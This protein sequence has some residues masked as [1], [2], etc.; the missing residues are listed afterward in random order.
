MQSD[1]DSTL[2]DQQLQEELYKQNLQSAHREILELQT[3]LQ[4]AIGNVTD[5]S[6]SAKNEVDVDLNH[7]IVLAHIMQLQQDWKVEHESQ[8]QQQQQPQSPDE[9]VLL[10]QARIDELTTALASATN[11]EA[12]TA[13]EVDELRDVVVEKDNTI[14]ELQQQLE[15]AI[16][17][18]SSNH[19]TTS[20]T[21][22]KDIMQDIYSKTCEMY[23]PEAPD[24]A[25]PQYSTQDIVKRLRVV[26][27][28]VTTERLA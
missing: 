28:Q 22:L 16:Q 26:L 14:A 6:N 13:V 10:L 7:P 20:A 11:N 12:S 9:N 5:T 18:S 4:V 23:D 2:L 8:Q 3:Q 15:D 17:N 21:E 19:T 25:E 1:K 24:S 27:K